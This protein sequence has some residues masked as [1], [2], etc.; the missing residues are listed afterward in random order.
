MGHSY[1]WMT[2][3]EPTMAKQGEEKG[4]CSVCGD[5]ISRT[6]DRLELEYHWGEPVEFGNVTVEFY[7]EGDMFCFRMEG[8]YTS[9][10]LMKM[11]EDDEVIPDMHIMSNQMKN[12]LKK[13]DS[14]QTDGNLTYVTMEG[15]GRKWVYFADMSDNT[16]GIIGLK[17]NIEKE[18]RAC[19]AQHIVD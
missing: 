9:A 13:R 10:T 7:M 11:L 14:I 2:V 1:Q 19:A 4:T 18:M 17:V 12:V 8:P 5:T 16:P 3:R 6:L 15:Y